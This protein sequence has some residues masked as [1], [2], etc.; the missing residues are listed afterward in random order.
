[1]KKAPVFPAAS[2][3]AALSQADRQTIYVQTL[4]NVR[5]QLRPSQRLLSRFLHGRVVEVG[6]EFLEE[7]LFR[8]SAVLGG[9][10]SAIIVIAIWYSAAYTTGFS[11]SGSEIPVGYVVGAGLGLGLERL[12]LL[13]RRRS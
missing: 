3:P 11:L 4:V 9:L 5:H 6:T 10:T 8:P 1:M 12:I 7:T 13:F 2:T